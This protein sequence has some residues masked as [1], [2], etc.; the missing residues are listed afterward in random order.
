MYVWNIV[1]QTFA[2]VSMETLA[3]D[4][5]TSTQDV[6]AETSRAAYMRAYRARK[7]AAALQ[8][9][10]R[11][12][13]LATDPQTVKQAVEAKAKKAAYMKAYRARKKAETLMKQT[14]PVTTLATMSE[15]S[16]QDVE[17]KGTNAA[18]CK[19]YRARKKAEVGQQVTPVAST[20]NAVHDVGNVDTR[21]GD[22]V[23]DP[24]FVTYWT[25]ARDRF[26]R[27]FGALQFGVACS[28]CDRLWCDAQLREVP[29]KHHGILRQHFPDED[30]TRFAVCSNCYCK[31]SSDRIPNMS[32]SHGF[33]Y[34]PKPTHLP[35]LDPVSVRLI[36]PRLPFMQIRRLRQE[37]SYGIVG[38]I[39]NVCVYI[40]IYI[41]IHLAT[42]FSF[43]LLL[44]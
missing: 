28:V 1:I 23:R 29:S 11:A 18:Y 41:Y 17:S 2:V 14:A 27:T 33:R 22:F 30:V 12:T 13:N 42:L 26:Q 38:Q 4:L 20:D 16:T 25:R 32:R 21:V 5:E 6:E 9:T 39:V 19:A 36:P 35:E 3:I 8:R 24:M 43:F 44:I 15:T 31:L 40:Y 34:P 10:T 37:G 7:K